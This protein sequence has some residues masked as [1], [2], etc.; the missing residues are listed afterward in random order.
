MNNRITRL[1]K[2]TPFPSFVLIVFFII[3]SIII[4]PYFL[5]SAYLSGL[6]G[7]Y[8]PLTILTLGQAIVLFAGGIDISVG[9]VMSL[10]NVLIVQMIAA[11]VDPVLSFVLALLLSAGIGAINGLV[12]SYLRVSPLL[13][14]LATSSIAAGGALAIQPVPG[15]SIPIDYVTWYSSTYFE[16]PAPIIFIIAFLVIWLIIYYSPMGKKIYA[17]GENLKM[18][19]VSCIR[20][21]FVRFFSFVLSGLAAGI[22]G[23]AVCGSIG[24]GSASVGTSL[25]LMSV[26]A[27]VIGGISLA[28][29]IGSILGALFGAVFLSLVFNT[30]LAL[31]VSPFFQDLLSGGIILASILVTSIVK[32]TE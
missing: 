2:W 22:A 19:Y 8:V 12:V 4:S 3:L 20:V 1:T 31:H 16:I 29:G 30:V 7:A 27:C 5:T 6:I 24:S 28:G 14:T 21:S 10:V 9:A 17:T 32:K 23:I 25:T 18:A 11:K 26:A 15:G 13:V